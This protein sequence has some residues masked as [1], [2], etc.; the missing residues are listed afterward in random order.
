MPRKIG[1]ADILEHVELFQC[2]R[3]NRLK[4]E[5][6][7]L[8]PKTSITCSPL[9]SFLAPVRTSADGMTCH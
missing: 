7:L 8:S 5:S 4:A 2:V 3:E 1:R 6:I 9:V